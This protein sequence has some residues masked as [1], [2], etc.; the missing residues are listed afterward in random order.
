MPL[1]L[2]DDS[3]DPWLDAD[4][5]DR[6]TIRHVVR[7]IPADAMTHWP[8]SS[9]VNRPGNDDPTLIERVPTDST[10]A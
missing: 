8:V 5:T 7:H 6:E 4:L 1:V 9:R 10:G 3:L 2:D